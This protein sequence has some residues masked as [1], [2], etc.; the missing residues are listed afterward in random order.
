MKIQK[1]NN[2]YIIVFQVFWSTFQLKVIVIHFSIARINRH[3]K[4]Y[5]YTSIDSFCHLYSYCLMIYWGHDQPWSIHSRLPP[6]TAYLVLDGVVSLLDLLL[7][8]QDVLLQ[9]TDDGL[10]LGLLCLVLLDLILVVVDVLLQA[11]ELPGGR[12]TRRL[13]LMANDGMKHNILYFYIFYKNY[14]FYE[15]FSF[16]LKT[17]LNFLKTKITAYY[18]NTEFFYQLKNN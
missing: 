18:K 5:N 2:A 13:E 11:R 14:Y 12:E 8:A 3:L 7:Q 17:F 1:L 10:Q 15:M 9:V 4:Q 16:K 6:S